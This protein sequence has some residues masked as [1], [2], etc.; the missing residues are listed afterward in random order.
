MAV[1]PSSVLESLGSYADTCPETGGLFR[2]VAGLM[3]SEAT[4]NK[5]LDISPV[6]KLFGRFFQA[7]DDYQNLASTEVSPPTA[8]STPQHT[9]Q[10]LTAE[11]HSTSTKKALPKTSAKARSPCHSSTPFD[12]TVHS[13]AVS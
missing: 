2:L 5:D 11:S 8:S 13:E 9:C 10:P 12:K 3:R 4:T 1:S 6:M 7:R